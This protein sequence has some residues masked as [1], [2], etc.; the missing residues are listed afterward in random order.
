MAMTSFSQAFAL[1]SSQLELSAASFAKRF[2]V[3]TKIELTAPSPY[4]NLTSVMNAL[5]YLNPIG[6]GTGIGIIR[7][8]ASAT[9]QGKLATLTAAGYKCCL[10]LSYNSPANN[11]ASSTISP[12]TSI[13]IGHVAL[14]EGGLE[15]DN[16]G[17]GIAVV[18]GNSYTDGLGTFTGW[19]AAVAMQRDLYT[20]FSASVPIALWSLAVPTDGASNSAAVTA[21]T[22]LGTT[23]AA[24]CN[25][26]NVHFYPHNGQPG[27]VELAGTVSQETGYTSS[28]PFVITESGF[29]DKPSTGTSLYG[30][31]TVNAK[32]TLNLLFDVYLAGCQFLSLYELMNDN[33]TGGTNFEDFWGLFDNNALP[34]QS[35]VALHNLFS[36]IGDSSPATLPRLAYTVTGL[37][38]GHT[39]ALAKSDGTYILAVWANFNIFPFGSPATAPTQAVTVSLTRSF[40]IA[41]F[42]PMQNAASIAGNASFLTATPAMTPIS[43]FSNANSVTLSVIDHV[44]L[45]RL[46]P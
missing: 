33:Q 4:S 38:N 44:M 28:Q 19:Q 17:F 46:T 9:P 43:T 27:S 18:G 14:L 15:V 29:N 31:Q 35:A 10:F 20:T 26:G 3:Q 34:K 13:G 30:N 24:I 25:W 11:T 1:G 32:Y 42:D 6:I 5:S 7:Q 8:G 36:L 37:S 22:Q 45:V 39:L 40:T 2:G 12:I 21:A 41:L 23:I 16:T